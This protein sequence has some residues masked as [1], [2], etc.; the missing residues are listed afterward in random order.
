[1][2]HAER[3]GMLGHGPASRHISTWGSRSRPHLLSIHLPWSVTKRMS[4]GAIEE[5]SLVSYSSDHFQ[6]TSFCPLC[7]S[8]RIESQQC[9]ASEKCVDL[10]S[11]PHRGCKGRQETEGCMKTFHTIFRLSSVSSWSQYCFLQSSCLRAFLMLAMFL[12]LNAIPKG[13]IKRIR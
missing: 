12:K 5:Y 10:T 3:K 7:T 6:L 13:G 2:Q 9:C 4:M 1:M 11:V 8:F